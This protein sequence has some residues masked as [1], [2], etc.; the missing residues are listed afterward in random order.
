MDYKFLP[1]LD[2]ALD[3]QKSFKFQLKSSYMEMLEQLHA[4]DARIFSQYCAFGVK[5]FS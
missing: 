3:L 2:V 5:R 4:H 1:N